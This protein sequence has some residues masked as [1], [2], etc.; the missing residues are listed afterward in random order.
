MKQYHCHII[1]AS[2][3]IPEGIKKSWRGLQALDNTFASPFYTTDFTEIVARICGRVEVAIWQERDE[4]VAIFP[5]ERR[6]WN[7]AGPVGQFLSDYDG[8]IAHP[9]F[10]RD[11]RQILRDCRLVAWDFKHSPATDRIFS[12]FQIGQSQV[13]VSH[14]QDGFEAF[15]KERR[16]AGLNHQLSEY[17]RKMRKLEQDIGPLRFVPSSGDETVLQSLMALKSAQY[18]RNRWR[19]VFS[20]PW[21]KDVLRAI[22]TTQTPEFA[23]MLCALYA[24][25]KLVAV[26]Y[27]LRSHGLRHGWFPAYDVKFSKYSPGIMLTLKLLEN[28]SQLGITSIDWGSGEHPHKQLVMN[29]SLITGSGTI[30]LPCAATWSRRLCL[31]VYK[32][33]Y[34]VRCLI[35]KTPVG[36]LARRLRDG[37]K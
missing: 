14:V 21:V 33:P 15:V 1:N 12:P 7:F 18:R 2:E 36:A 9:D 35:S 31:P 13:V 8:L 5:F 22:Q 23:G 28:C 30:E 24:G 37:K 20:M 4:V 3:G 11:P 19:D 25:E 6:S 32:L 17:F 27:G 29:S 34:K 10:V 26:H 16:A